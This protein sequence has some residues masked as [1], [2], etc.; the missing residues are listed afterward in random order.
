[1]DYHN[2]SNSIN[3][4]QNKKAEPPK[5]VVHGKT[6]TVKK[7]FF[8]QMKEDLFV[9]DA[10]T[11]LKSV[12]DNVIVPGI[13]KLVLDMAWNSIVTAMYNRPPT[14]SPTSSIYGNNPTFTVYPNNN[15]GNGYWQNQQK[16]GPV[17]QS[18]GSLYN[19]ILFNDSG[20]ATAVLNE[21]Q[22][23]IETYGAVSVADMF[24]LAGLDVPNNNWVLDRWRWTNIAGSSVVPAPQGGFILSMST[25]PRYF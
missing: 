10:K 14:N 7:G 12:K 18:S 8:K 9:A 16:A 13:K 6:S 11:V 1:M 19:D 22:M 2:S 4:D 20:D 3:Q 23:R 24:M 5:S 25:K 15:I 17:M 21:M